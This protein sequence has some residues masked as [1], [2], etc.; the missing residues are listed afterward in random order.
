MNSELEEEKLENWD[1]VEKRETR[2]RYTLDRRM[3]ERRKRYWWAVI[4]PVILGVGITALISWGVYVT[5]TTYR[6]SANY[7]KTFVQHI[8]KE[9]EREALVEHRLEVIRADYTNRIDSLKEDLKTS[10]QDIKSV[11]TQIYRILLN[12]QWIVNPHEIPPEEKP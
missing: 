12:R 4:F 3:S 10:L 2:R 6:I 8:E 11:Q 1:G 7:E 5:H 9:I